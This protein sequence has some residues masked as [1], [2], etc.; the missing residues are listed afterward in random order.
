[1]TNQSRGGEP[2][3][4]WKRRKASCQ[5]AGR[6]IDVNGSR[7]TVDTVQAKWRQTHTSERI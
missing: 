3:S 4:G 7:S 5:R 1:M 2:V 6:A